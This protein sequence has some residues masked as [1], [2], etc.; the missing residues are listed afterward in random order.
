MAKN[1]V[2][3]DKIGGQDHYESIVA[4]APIVNGQFVDLGANDLDYGI[5]VAKATK[6]VEGAKPDALTCTV[7][8][9]YGYLDYDE[10]EQELKAGK[11]G[12]ALHIK[13][14]QIVS[15]NQENAASLKEGDPVTVGKDGKGVKKATQSD[16]VIG[17]VIRL[18]YLNYVGDLVVVRFN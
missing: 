5:E 10:T 4:E 18:D 6:S 7:F 17:K 11:I 12:R 9:D 3:L 14:G 2:R 8:V 15:F 16:V 13:K 1:Y